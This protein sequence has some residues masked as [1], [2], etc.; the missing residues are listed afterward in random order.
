M[1]KFISAQSQETERQSG[2]KDRLY[3]NFCYLEIYQTVQKTG[4][5]FL[6]NMAFSVGNKLFAGDFH[7]LLDEMNAGMLQS[8]KKWNW[9]WI[10]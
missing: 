3:R 1:K 7:A 10:A 8:T 2:N 9:K 5:H 6:K 4:D